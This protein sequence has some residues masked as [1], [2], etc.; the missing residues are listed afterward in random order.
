MTKRR[1]MCRCSMKAFWFRYT[2]TYS[3]AALQSSTLSI[4]HS[5]QQI[6]DPRTRWDEPRLEPGFKLILSPDSSRFVGN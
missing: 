4:R 6:N 2:G 5:S 3:G 1:W